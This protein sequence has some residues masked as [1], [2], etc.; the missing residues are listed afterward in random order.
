MAPGRGCQLK[1]GQTPI[2]IPCHFRWT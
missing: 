1:N 2:H